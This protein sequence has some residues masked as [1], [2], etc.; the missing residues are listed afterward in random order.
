MENVVVKLWE[1]DPVDMVERY[2]NERVTC[3]YKGVEYFVSTDMDTKKRFIEV[4][5]NRLFLDCNG[6][7]ANKQRGTKSVRTAVENFEDMKKIQDYFIDQQQWSFYLLFTLSQNTA[8]RISDLRAALWSDFFYKNG[9][10]KEVWDVRKF[11]RDRGEQKTG[12]AKE[13]YIN[14]AVQE[15]FRLFLEHETSIDLKRDYDEPVFKQLHGTHKGKVITEE[16]YRKA[17]IKVSKSLGYEVRSHSMRRGFGKA[18][19][20][21]RPNDNKAKSVLMEL[22]NHSSEK[23]TNRYIGETSKMEKECLEDFGNTYRKYVMEGE[24]IPFLVRKPVSVYDNSEL[25]N[26]IMCA[27]GKILDIKDETNPVKLVE[28][29]NELLDGLESIA[30]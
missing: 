24:D 9:N 20:E 19:M 22:F 3:E 7:V 11:N 2:A 5:G 10:M 28:L 6:K 18:V 4:D 8:R 29:Y 26:Y 12:K 16:G 14:S 30:K 17:L 23:M 25:R 13:L 15:A 27:F 1:H 21:L